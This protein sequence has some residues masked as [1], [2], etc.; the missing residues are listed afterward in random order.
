MAHCFTDDPT[1]I[2][3]EYEQKSGIKQLTPKLISAYP[4][5][6]R[7]YLVINDATYKEMMSHSFGL[8]DYKCLE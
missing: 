4:E 1:L 5:T 6:N 7:G 3:K 2:L 8:K